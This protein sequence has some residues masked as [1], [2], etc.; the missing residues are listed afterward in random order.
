MAMA[1]C[2]L[3]QTNAARATLAEGIKIAETRLRQRGR[4]D[5]ND[6]IIAQ[7][8]LHEALALVTGNPPSAADSK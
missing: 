2:Q 7:S 4:I 8:L 5:W 1:Q 6:G 3:G